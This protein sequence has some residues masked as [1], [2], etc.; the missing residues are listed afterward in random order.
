MILVDSSVWIDHL[1]RGDAALAG[2]LANAQALCHP[3]VIGEIA[4][5]RLANRAVVLGLLGNLPPAPSGTHAEVMTLIETRT[6]F[7]LGIGYVD[8]HLLAA[9]LLTGSGT[10]LWTRDKR[11]KAAAGALGCAA[12]QS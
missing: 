3:A 2:V 11:L 7:G 6:L 1:R 4:L 5:G 12:P 9:T 8:A 10:T